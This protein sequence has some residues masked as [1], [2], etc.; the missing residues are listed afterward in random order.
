MHTVLTDNVT[1]KN[2]LIVDI[3]TKKEI[4]LFEY[5]EN[6]DELFYIIK[7]YE[8]KVRVHYKYEF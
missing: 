6:K 4:N 1:L 5:L 7:K 2:N 8:N 3:D